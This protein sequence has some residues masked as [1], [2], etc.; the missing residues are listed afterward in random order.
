MGPASRLVPAQKGGSL[1]LVLIRERVLCPGCR[2]E[3]YI[4]RLVIDGSGK[5]FTVCSHCGQLY[6]LGDGECKPIAA[7]AITNPGPILESRRI[8][9]RMN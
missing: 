7:A 3:I 4:P 5:R 1:S 6:E 8:R 2:N 9:A